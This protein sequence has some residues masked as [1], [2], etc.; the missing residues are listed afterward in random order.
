MVGQIKNWSISKRITAAVLACTVVLSA[1]AVVTIPLI[2]APKAVGETPG[3]AAYYNARWEDAKTQVGK[4]T[5]GTAYTD[6][7]G[8]QATVAIEGPWM[9]ENLQQKVED[10]KLSAPWNGVAAGTKPTDTVNGG[11]Y[12]AAINPWKVTTAEQLR[13]CVGN[14]QSFQLQNDI[15]LGG[16][17][18]RTWGVPA[19]SSATW[20][21][22]GNGYTIYNLYMDTS[23]AGTGFF[24]SNANL[25]VKNLRISNSYANST[26]NWVSLFL[27]G[28][29]R[30]HS[31]TVQ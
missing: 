21:A 17:A 8:S 19:A 11:E 30:V 16:Y 1:A 25:T 5:V 10:G 3:T 18:G 4:V 14:G 9:L 15:D 24:G 6:Y 20:S 12:N 23:S 22:D 2:N 13:Y 26:G 7:Q 31:E 29:A 28:T 27:V